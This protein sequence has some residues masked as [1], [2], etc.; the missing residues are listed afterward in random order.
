MSERPSNRIAFAKTEA[1]PL[2]GRPY[3]NPIRASRLDIR[4]PDKSPRIVALELDEIII[5]RAPEVHLQVLSAELSRVHMRIHRCR[6]GWRI[7]DLDS[8]NGL[9]LNGHLIHAAI[10]RDGDLIQV[11]DVEFHFEAGNQ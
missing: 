1:T 2:V 3:R 7:E 4:Q 11:G 6:Q 8:R 5:G 10:L 9:Y